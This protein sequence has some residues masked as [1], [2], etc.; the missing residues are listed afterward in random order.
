MWGKSSG[1]GNNG[2]YNQT[3]SPNSVLIEVGGID[4][5]ADELKRT[6]DLL[7]DAIADVY[8]SSRDAEKAA[9]P[10]QGGTQSGGN[11]GRD[12]NRFLNGL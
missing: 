4:N 2:E 10:D 9:A 12:I 3:L 7:A 11:R 5:S 1:N 8:W 6:A